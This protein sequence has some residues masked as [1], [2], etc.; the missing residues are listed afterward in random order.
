MRSR[1]GRNR[2]ASAI[3]D[4]TGFRYPMSE[5]VVEPGTNYLVHRS[6]SDGQ[7]SVVEHPLNNL[8]RYLKGKQGDPF[9]VKNARPRPSTETVS[10]ITSYEGKVNFNTQYYVHAVGLR[11]LK[12]ITT[13]SGA[14]SFEAN[15]E[16][17]ISSGPVSFTGTGSLDATFDTDSITFTGSASFIPTPSDPS[18]N[19]NLLFHAELSSSR[20]VNDGES[21]VFA[22][23]D[24]TV[25]LA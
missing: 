5:M 12:G 15:P 25:S 14:G 11:L 1:V 7:W 22:I 16:V 24:V 21:I 18:S 10:A 3:C 13:F 6:V 19:G 4:R 9:P 20:T 2:G 17:I 8:G 23:G